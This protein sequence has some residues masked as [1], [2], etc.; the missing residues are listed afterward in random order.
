MR[1]FR[2]VFYTVVVVLVLVAGATAWAIRYSAIDPVS[3]HP[4]YDAATI[5]H[6]AQLAALGD[7][8]TCHSAAGEPAYS[9][10]RPVPTPF[11]TVYSTNITPDPD[12]GIG[13]WS[14]AAF[15][16][17]M[18]EGI[19]R[20]GHHLYPA[21]PYNHFT[22]ATDGDIKAVYA[23]LMTLPPV[24]A[25]RHA[26]RLPFPFNIRP[27][28]AGWNLLFLDRGPYRSN[29]SQSDAW[30]RGAYLAEGLGHCGSCHTPKNAFGAET[31]KRFAGARAEGWIAPPLNDTSPAPVGWT[32][33]MVATY[34]R[35]GHQH[36]HGK[37]LGPMSEVTENLARLP[38]ADIDA[39]GIYIASV[40]AG[41]RR[42]H[43]Q[44]RRRQGGEG[45]LR[46]RPSRFA[47]AGR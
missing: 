1:A 46:P 38:Q 12:T 40:H 41:R 30:N 21:F 34:L 16:R 39:L 3:D 23:F 26:N 11:G 9:G 7:C 29:P 44:G 17:A 8:S 35:A 10:G 36:L 37:A 28:L 22:K 33:E 32:A 43:D 14:E 24:R 2:I 25:E 18:R 5:A 15:R 47:G 20:E 6:G 42:Q 13:K 45:R 4:G 31:D 27:L 19:D